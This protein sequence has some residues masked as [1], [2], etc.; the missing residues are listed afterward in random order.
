LKKPPESGALDLRKTYVLKLR[1][2]VLHVNV[3]A[4]PIEV[5]RLADR[6]LRGRPV[7]V[8][9]SS[10]PRAPLLYVSPEAFGAGIYRGMARREARHWERSLICLTP[11]D[12]LYQQAQQKLI[13]VVS[14]FTPVL[15]PMRL[16]SVFLDMTG[17]ELLFGKAAEAASK[18]RAELLRNLSLDPTLGV[19]RNKLVSRVATKVMRPHGLYQV[20]EGHEAEFL[21]PL[22]VDYLPGVGSVTSGKLL[23]ELG[24]RRIGEL[25][26]IPVPLLVQLFGKAGVELHDKASGEDHSLVRD[27]AREMP[28]QIQQGIIFS[29]PTNDDDR[30]LAELWHLCERV[31]NTLRTAGEVASRSYLEGVYVDG[32]RID[33]KVAH[34]PPTQSDF[35]L[36][37]PWKNSWKKFMERRLQ[38]KSLTL[39]LQ[40]LQLRYEQL[41]FTH[42]QRERK[43]LATLDK[44]RRRYGE[45]SVIIHS[46]S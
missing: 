21:H 28:R 7:A 46:P 44:L 41:D 24:I 40:G 11:N 19:A 17:T 13:E 42:D 25:A 5:E 36:F 27:T 26:A 1:V 18:I 32:L 30:L 23:R 31:G 39:T 3:S 16:G 10:S 2:S 6:R 35:D 37:R 20:Y 22:A 38:L 33:R 8:A 9:A 43:L 14:R 12:R 34:V 4:F 29:E 15:E 45:K